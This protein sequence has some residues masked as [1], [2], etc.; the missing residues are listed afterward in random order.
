MEPFKLSL[1]DALGVMSANPPNSFEKYNLHWKRGTDALDIEFYAIRQGGRWKQSDGQMR[2]EGLFH[3]YKEA[4]KLL[5]PEDDHH[6]WSDLTLRTILENDVTVLMGCSDS[7]KTYSMVRYG[8]T[9]WFAFPNNTLFIVSSTDVRGLELRIWGKMKELFNRARDRYPDLPGYVLEGMRSITPDAIDDRNERGRLLTKGLVCVPCVS[10]NHYVGLGK[11]VGIKQDRLRHLGDEVQHMKSS[12]LDAY[13]NWYGKPDFKGVMSGNPLDEYDPLGKAAEPPEGWK[14]KPV[15]TKTETWRSTFFNAAV[16]CL[17]GLDSPNFDYPKDEP[18]RYPYMIGHKKI[19]AV[20]KTHGRDSLHF[21]SQCEGVIK[22][23]MVASRVITRELCRI[24]GAHDKVVWEGT[25]RTKLYAC[26]PAYGGHDR[27]VG[28]PLEFGLNADERQVIKLHPWEL[29]PVKA[30]AQETPEDQIAH[31]IKERTV[32]LGI[33]TSNIFYDSFGKGTVGAAM[34]RVFGFEVPVPVNSGD[35]TTERPVRYD[36]FV[37]DIHGG[38][39]LKKCSEHYSKFVTE[40]WFSV[41]ECIESNQL[42]ELLEDVMMEG[43]MREYYVVSG[44]RIEVEPKDD[45]RERTERSPDLFDTL[46]VGLEGARQRGF[47]IERI[48]EASAE[49]AGKSWLLELN[50][51][52]R[53]LVQSLRLKVAA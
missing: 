7:N 26:D 48:G 28:M 35:K 29:I 34:A 36:L 3:H 32:E 41:R 12:F 33:P 22:P 14:S 10:N 52:H 46:A 2:G 17:Y 24:H 27:C 39:R 49:N 44:N 23:G 18:T 15:P 40:M 38:R 20:I 53:K 11:M 43:C 4:Q 45:M 51:R 1:R 37:P 25:T 50:E 6:R 42:F 5:W 31:Y 16:V 30:K 19:E 47:K 13:T 8:L 9:D 21:S